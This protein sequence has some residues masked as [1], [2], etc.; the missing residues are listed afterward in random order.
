[1]AYRTGMLKAAQGNYSLE[2]NDNKGVNLVQNYDFTKNNFGH[3]SYNYLK[4]YLKN[5]KIFKFSISR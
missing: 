4:K 1:M 5:I 2:V 3:L